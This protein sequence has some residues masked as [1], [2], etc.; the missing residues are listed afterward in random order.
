MKRNI[1]IIDD[2]PRH[3]RSLVNG[4]KVD[5]YD[6]LQASSVNEGLMLL[7]QNQ[8]IQVVILDLDLKSGGKGQEFL[9]QTQGG[10]RPLKIIVLTGHENML[11][12][13]TAEQLGVYNYQVKS[14]DKIPIQSMRFAV[15]QAY[16]SLEFDLLEKKFDRLKKIQE[17]INSSHRLNE[18]LHLICSSVL[19][20]VGGYTTHFRLFNLKKGDFDLAAYKGPSISIESYFDRSKLLGEYYSGKAAYEKRPIIIDDLQKD[21]PFLEMRQ[22]YFKSKRANQEVKKY[23]NNVRSAYIVPI[24]TGLFDTEVDAVLNVSSEQVS[25]FQSEEVRNLVHE[26]VMYAALAI[27]KEWQ[28]AKRQELHRDYSGISEMLAEVSRQLQGGNVQDRILDVVIKRISQIV[29]PEMISVFLLNRKTGYLQNVAEF[30]GDKRVKNGD[31]FYPPGRSL[32]GWIY[33]H[34][35][36]IR[37]PDLEARNNTLPADDPRFDKQLGEELLTN[38]PS[39]R[40]AHYLG[41][42]MNIGRNKVGVIRVVNKKSDYYD[43]NGAEA[44]ANSLLPR[45]FSEDCETVLKI[46]ASHLAVSISNAELIRRLNWKIN[47]LQTLTDV[48]RTIGSNSGVDIDELLELIVT[49]TA[50]VMD[51]EIC[52]LFIREKSEN[53]IVLKQ[54]YP[55]DMYIAKDAF[56]KLGENKTGKVA[57]KGMPLLEPQTEENYKGKYDDQITKYLLSKNGKREGRKKGGKRKPI[58][59]LMIVPIISDDKSTLTGKSIIGVLK[60]INKTTR[61]PFDEE[62]LSIFNTFASQIGVA[63]ALANRNVE[64]SQLV[65]GVCHEVANTSGLVPTHVAAIKK[66]LAHFE[67]NDYKRKTLR[68][69]EIINNT[70]FQA[71]DF[72]KDILGFGRIKGKVEGGKADLN[73]NTLVSEAIR[74]LSDEPKSLRSFTNIKLVSRLTDKPLV[75]S[76]YKTPFIHVV[77]NIIINAYQAMERQREGRLVI[78]TDEDET[79]KIA[80]IRFKDNGPGIKR[81]D[82]DHIFEPDYTTREGGNGLGLWMVKT[83]L[84][85]MNGNISVE[86]SFRH[87][88][89][90]TIQ[91][92][93]ILR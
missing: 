30:R 23:L 32:T 80:Y 66:W 84:N 40:V 63:L 81:K 58:E 29:N 56:Y 82:L 79:G 88:A 13:P 42:P 6:F 65:G 91:M 93:T 68:S 51:A 5:G 67:D 72:S 11:H 83:Y 45:G 71:V 87:G 59:S 39:K 43:V 18:I 47:Q 53:R 4:L 46:T 3:R 90:F 37:L 44:N 14:D 73:V 89:T 34:N 86:S 20:L 76:V 60:V 24:S 85:R 9:K 35:K 70:A 62:D 54:S 41:V 78:E 7:A 28:K 10:P 69:L 15:E 1:L 61:L 12:A 57:L 52:L 26:F 2:D 17:K 16:K 25:F 55:S 92:P 31:E 8:D 21:P 75:C 38:I 77:R 64:L 22:K 33:K 19:E 36:P 50:E 27:T 49:K 74:Q 48:A